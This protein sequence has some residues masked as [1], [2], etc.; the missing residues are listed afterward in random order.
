MTEEVAGIKR[1]E[2]AKS[3]HLKN[4]VLFSAL[5][6]GM[7]LAIPFLMAG[8]IALVIKSFPVEAYQTFLA[9][10]LGGTVCQLLNLVYQSTLG[11]LSL[12]LLITIS[13]SYGREK[14][15]ERAVLYPLVAV[16]SYI[17]CVYGAE[18]DAP[19]DIFGPPWIFTVLVVSLGSAALFYRLLKFRPL[20]NRQYT[21]GADV[22]FNRALTAIWPAVLVVAFF[23]LVNVL[24]NQLLG[25]I[26]LQSVGSE[27]FLWL[28][29]KIGRNFGGALLY[30]FFIH[31]LWFFGIHGSNMLDAVAKQF[32]EGGLLIN[33]QLLEQG[34]APTEVYSKTFL[35][36][37]VLMGG[38]G[39]CICLVIA[40]LLVCRKKNNRRLA[41]IGCFPVIFNVSELMVFG[42]PVVLNPI[43][44]V[45]FLLTPLVLTCIS[46]LATVLG[47]VPM[48]VHSVEWTTPVLISGY[49]ATGSLA[50]SVLQAVNI[51]VGVLLYMPFVRM[52]ESRQTKRMQEN[53]QRLNDM[54]R[55][56]E[57]RG[58]IPSLFTAERQLANTAKM[59]ASD[60]RFATRHGD[61]ELYYQPQIQDDGTPFGGEA[62]LRWKHSTVGFLYPPLVIA[63]AKEDHFLDELGLL[64]IEWTCRDLEI[65]TKRFGPMLKLSVNIS[66]DQLAQPDFTLKVQEILDRYD[67]PRE[68][69]GFEVTEQVALNSTPAMHDSL[70][71]LRQMGV[72]IIMDDFGMGHSSMSYLQNTSFQIVKLDGSLIRQLMENQRSASIIRS[73]QQLADSLGFRLLA[74][75]VETAEQRDK[76]MEL[77]CTIYQGYLYSPAIPFEDFQKYLTEHGVEPREKT[78][79]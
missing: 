55:H 15:A 24:L 60:L 7:V 58:A 68:Y 10:F 69:L 70:E 39:T 40:M 42:F 21:E 33:Q 14:D 32:F 28:F 6:Q 52:A 44:V 34:T 78:I 27:W 20:K 41:K 4:T 5:R 38:C 57:S 30:V 22:L 2:N 61:L 25:T 31:V 48:A 46:S 53:I 45:P 19:L 36:A 1:G 16:C 77:G 12:V 3:F 67:F 79:V 73:I 72:Q 63:L 56:G 13:Y 37:F 50:G 11:A 65:L 62:L 54:V 29:E 18:T 76:L 66:P 51:L 9:S 49:V 71:Q 74:E 59:L 47:L 26:A 75:Y 23:S 17:A 35:D 8:S 64:L 43:M